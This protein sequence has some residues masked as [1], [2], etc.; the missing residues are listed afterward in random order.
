MHCN[1]ARNTY[2]DTH[3][4]TNNTN[5]I[6]DL[7][8]YKQQTWG[9]HVPMP[10]DL[11]VDPQM[12]YGLPMCNDKK[13]SQNV[14]WSWYFNVIISRGFRLNHLNGSSASIGRWENT[15]TRF[16]KGWGFIS[17][18]YVVWPTFLL[19]NVFIAL[20]GSHFWFLFYLMFVSLV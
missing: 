20:K 10:F 19:M 1:T 11:R 2:T 12:S 17:R 7:S 16:Q 3:A 15:N 14:T 6:L 4:H 9:T 13:S 8:S 5:C 18:N